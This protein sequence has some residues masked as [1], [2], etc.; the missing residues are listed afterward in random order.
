LL[1]KNPEDR[2]PNGAALFKALS[3]ALKSQ[4]EPEAPPPSTISSLTIA[5]R[6]RLE[7]ASRPLLALPTREDQPVSPRPAAEPVKA[8]PPARP[9]RAFPFL[10]AAGL[11]GFLLFV[12]MCAWLLSTGFRLGSQLLRGDDEPALTTSPPAVIEPTVPRSLPKATRAPATSTVA[13][14]A[15]PTNT[16]AP[17]VAYHLQIV[18]SGQD[19]LYLLNAGQVELPLEPIQLGNPPNYVLGSQWQLSALQP[20]ECVLL[21][22]ERAKDKKIKDMDC[23]QAGVE[24]SLPEEKPFWASFYNIYFDGEFVGMCEQGPDVC[25]VIFPD[26]P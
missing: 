20:G 13:A 4:R 22:V 3:A 19:G 18:K 16:S 26:L 5:E 23:Q 2:F 10:A 17:P 21:K 12:F 8:L 25:E 6:V 1:A 11:F 24:V 7:T 15:P 9:R 14:L